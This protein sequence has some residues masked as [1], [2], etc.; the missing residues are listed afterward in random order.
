MFLQAYVARSRTT[1]LVVVFIKGKNCF[2]Y[3]KTLRDF[4]ILAQV[5]DE[6][7]NQWPY[8]AEST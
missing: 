3:L 6:E 1:L 2:D 8:S 4:S 5:P 7:C